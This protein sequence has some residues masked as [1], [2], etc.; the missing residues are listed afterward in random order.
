MQAVLQAPCSAVARVTTRGNSLYS[1]YL[2]FPWPINKVCAIFG[3]RYR[4]TCLM[5]YLSYLPHAV[6]HVV[7]YSDTWSRQNRN[8]FVAALHHAVLTMD[9]IEIIDQKLLESGHSHMEFGAMHSTIERAKKT[10]KTFI[11]S[12][13]NTV[14]QTARNAALLCWRT[15]EP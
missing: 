6:K 5:L 2:S 4:A 11:P 3:L 1:T 13:W 10:A 7:L 12:H 8:R 9:K 14:I 15:T